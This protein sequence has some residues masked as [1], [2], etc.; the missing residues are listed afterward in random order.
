MI[1]LEESRQHGTSATFAS[2]GTETTE[3]IAIE[4]DMVRPARLGALLYRATEIVVL[5]R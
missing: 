3:M 4:E 1:C 2:R 5:C